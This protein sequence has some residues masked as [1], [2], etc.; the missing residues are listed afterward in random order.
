MK[1]VNYIA[2]P[3]LLFSVSV[4][5]IQA[6][7]SF[8]PWNSDVEVADETVKMRS[9]IH[10]SG[11]YVYNGPQGGAYFLIRFFQIVISPQDGPNCRFRPTC[12][13]YGRNAVLKH[14][15]LLGAILAG[16]RL[17]RCNPYTPPGKDPVPDE[18]F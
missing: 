2:L 17:I 12:S 8:A 11:N 7:D 4:T 9:I 10:H 5:E 13:V 15:A 3:V 1:F 16:D 14:G 18:L 6:E